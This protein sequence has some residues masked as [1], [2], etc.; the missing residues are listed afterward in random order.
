MLKTRGGGSKAVWTM[1][2]KTDDL[3]LWGVPKCCI[4]NFTPGH[5]RK[6][7]PP[8]T[9]ANQ[10][11]SLET[12]NCNESFSTQLSPLQP[13]GQNIAWSVPVW[14]SYINIFSLPECILSKKIESLYFLSR[15]R[16]I[17]RGNPILLEGDKKLK[18][19]PFETDRSS[20]GSQVELFVVQQYGKN[21]P[22]EGGTNLPERNKI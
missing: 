8:T 5:L 19:V 4:L 21:C 16:N 22:M 3:A 11:P 2:K 12:G 10:D 20:G 9:M 6:V 18:L 13:S 17:W 15:S 1:L 14:A 7:D